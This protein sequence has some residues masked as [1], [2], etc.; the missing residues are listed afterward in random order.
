MKKS[1]FYRSWQL[2]LTN[3]DM[4]WVT[5][6]ILRKMVKK[7]GEVGNF[8]GLGGG[9]CKIGQKMAILDFPLFLQN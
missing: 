9:V 2:L 6:M 3:N 4:K 7:V 5:W 1:L 8:F